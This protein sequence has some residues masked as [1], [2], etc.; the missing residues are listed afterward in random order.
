MNAKMKIALEFATKA[1]D[2]QLRKYTGEPYIN[3]PIAVGDALKSLYKQTSNNMICAAILHDT[4]EDTDTTLFDINEN[5]GNDVA[6]L[7]YWLTDKSKKSDG[8][9]KQRKYI[10]AMHILGAPYNAQIIKLADLID[11]TSSIVKHDKDFAKV[12]LSEKRFILMQMDEYIKS[13]D[14][15]KEAMRVLVDSEFK[16]NQDPP[17]NNNRG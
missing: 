7:V 1:H 5:F 16:V 14:I 4:V 9:R 15:Y 10:D 8:N 2:G 12:Y 11:N 17:T 6:N 3:H 13:L